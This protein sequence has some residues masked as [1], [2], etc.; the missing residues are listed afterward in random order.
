MRNAHTPVL[1][2]G[3]ILQHVMIPGGTLETNIQL[4]KAGALACPRA[5]ACYSY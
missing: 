2:P 5:S 4:A 3:Q 1:E